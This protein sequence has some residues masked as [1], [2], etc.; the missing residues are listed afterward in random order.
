LNDSPFRLSGGQQQL[1]CL[2]RALAVGPEVLLLDE[3]T[4]SLDPVTTE[5][6]EALL[7]TL[8]P[9]LTLIVVTHNLGQAMRVSH[10]TMFFYQGALV[11][12][13]ATDDLFNR[14]SHT[15]TERYV[16]GRMG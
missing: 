13:G 6:I 14:P 11:E 4:S 1:L 5:S 2:A 10:Q 9:A 8:A 3:P 7:K 12:Y 15:D 16:T